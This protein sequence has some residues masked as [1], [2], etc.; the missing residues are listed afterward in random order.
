MLK[1]R[2]GCV[3]VAAGGPGNTCGGGGSTSASPSW[4]TVGGLGWIGVPWG[5][6]VWG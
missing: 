1:H 6:D 2:T 5:V 4:G 3:C